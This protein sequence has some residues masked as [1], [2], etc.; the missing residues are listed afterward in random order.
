MSFSES[1]YMR[2]LQLWVSERQRMLEGQVRETG[3][4]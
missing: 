3:E 4:S 1:T 2:V